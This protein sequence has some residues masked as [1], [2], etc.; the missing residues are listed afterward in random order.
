MWRGTEKAAGADQQGCECRYLDWPK[1]AP[2]MAVI[3][4][5]HKKS[6]KLKRSWYIQSG[7]YTWYSIKRGSKW[8]N[9][10]STPYYRLRNNSQRSFGSNHFASGGY[11]SIGCLLQPKAQGRSKATAE[12]EKDWSTFS[13]PWTNSDSQRSLEGGVW[14][15][16]WPNKI[17]Q[18]VGAYSVATMDKA[19]KVSNLFKEKDHATAS[20]QA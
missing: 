10:R 20:L 12:K 16:W 13:V 19:S 4:F 9:Q 17:V 5:N 2:G 15:F 6:R 8:R 18:Y 14:S 11:T 3:R 7:W 1:V